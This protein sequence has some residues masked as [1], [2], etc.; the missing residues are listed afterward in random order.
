M[1]DTGARRLNDAARAQRD[2]EDALFVD[3]DDNEREQ[4]RRL[5]LSLRDSMTTEQPAA[6]AHA[7]DPYSW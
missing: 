1:S 7:G 3:L 5:L 2:A 4:L 6:C